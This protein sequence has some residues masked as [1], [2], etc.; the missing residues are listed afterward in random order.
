MRHPD[1]YVEVLDA[2]LDKDMLIQLA[3]PDNRV[4]RNVIGKAEIHTTTV[5][6]YPFT[7]VP[8]RPNR[9][10]TGLVRE[11]TSICP[12]RQCPV[13]VCVPPACPVAGAV[14]RSAARC[15]R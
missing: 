4:Q 11:I 5:P 9:P 12:S 10:T 1:L 3:H 8:A 14:R 15:P 7:L 6:I 2:G 13:T